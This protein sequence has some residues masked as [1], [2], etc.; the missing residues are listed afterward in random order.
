MANQQSVEL[1]SDSRFY[2]SNDVRSKE[3]EGGRYLIVSVP[4]A[5]WI[6]LDSS[7][8]REMLKALMEGKTVQE[9]MD[10][11]AGETEMKLFVQLLS[12]LMARQF[13]SLSPTGVLVTREDTSRSMNIYLTQACNLRCKHCFMHSGVKLSGELTLQQWKEV[14]KGFR[15]WGGENLTITGGEPLM[16]PVFADIVEFASQQGL[17]VTVL[18]NGLLWTDALIERMYGHID[19]IQVS[20][21]GVNEQSN[22]AVRGIGHF[23]KTIENIV[24]LSNRGFR[25]SVATTFTL[26]NL[27]PDTKSLYVD[28]VA[29][30]KQ[31]S[32]FPIFFKITKKMLVGRNTHYSEADAKAYFDQVM[33]IER[34][35]EEN[36]REQNFMEGH[37]PNFVDANCGFGGVSVSADGNVYYCN[38]IHE[39]DSYG[40]VTEHPIAYFLEKGKELAVATD[41]DRVDPCKS[42]YLRY[43]CGG[44]CRIDDYNFKGRLQNF[45]GALQ[46]MEDAEVCRARLEKRMVEGFDFK[47]D[48]K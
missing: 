5:N 22:A 12:G 44:G 42:C 40:K 25:L 39:L 47:Y 46:R 20:L 36:S 10:V 27:T 28:L 17:K 3:I 45:K 24:K 23:D 48:F 6:V 15:E 37:V 43:V 16:N 38:R 14:L 34:S 30:I 11:C 1:S 7:V 33:E 31:H 26:E 8:Q 18:T 29:K 35:V 9:V 41:V 32:L 13:A 4:T 2:F 19:Q 21:D